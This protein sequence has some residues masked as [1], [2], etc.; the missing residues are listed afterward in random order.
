[1]TTAPHTTTGQSSNF[2][3]LPPSEGMDMHT[4][5]MLTGHMQKDTDIDRCGCRCIH[6]YIQ[7][8]YP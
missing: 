7:F 3:N 5:H 2:P 6:A 4:S 8:Q 1:M